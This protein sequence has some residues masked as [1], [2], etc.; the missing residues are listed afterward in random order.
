MGRSVVIFGSILKSN[1]WRVYD[2]F[3]DLVILVDF[4]AISIDLYAIRCFICISFVYFPCISGRMHINNLL[5]AR[6]ILM[7]FLMNLFWWRKGWMGGGGG[8][9][10]AC[11][12]MGTHSLSYRTN[13]W[14][15]TKLG[16]DKVIMALHMRLGFLAKS[17][18]RWI[19]VGVMFIVCA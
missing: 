8:V 1:F 17:T 12:C 14:M 19:Q 3:L 16:R 7:N 9:T 6:R 2:I 13:W 15:L 10:N 18:Q 5:Y 4:N 11:I